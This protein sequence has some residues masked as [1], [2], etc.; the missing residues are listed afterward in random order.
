MTQSFTPIDARNSS[1]VCWLA[2]GQS[3]AGNALQHCP[4]KGAGGSS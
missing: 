1:V 2:I 4:G 3:M